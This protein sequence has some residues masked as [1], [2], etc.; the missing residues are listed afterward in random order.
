MIY[1][2]Y[3][4]QLSVLRELGTEFSKKYPALAPMLAGQSADPDVERLIEGTAFLTG[5]IQAKLD[6]DFPELIHSMTSLMFPHYLYPIPSATIIRFSGRKELV[7]EQLIEKGAELLS[8]PVSGIRCIYTTVDNVTVYPLDVRI[9][10][11]SSKVMELEFNFRTGSLKTFDI[12]SLRIYVGG[13]YGEAAN[14][15]FELN[16]KLQAVVISDSRHKIVLRP[17]EAVK[18]LSE[19]FNSIIP[20]NQNMFGAFRKIQEYFQLPES[21]CFF[22][23]T[24]LAKL[25]SEESSFKV[26]FEFTDDRMAEYKAHKN[27]NFELFCVPAVNYFKHEADTINVDY[28]QREY[29]IN[30]YGGHNYYRIY[31]ID[32]VVGFIQGSVSQR[33]YKPFEQFNPS[34]S[35]CPVYSLIRRRSS[36]NRGIDV[37]ITVANTGSPSEFKSETLVISVTCTN[38]VLADRLRLGDINQPT[39]KLPLFIDY[40]NITHPTSSVE[41]PLGENLLWRLLSHIYLNQSSIVSVGALRSLL[42]LYVF[43][44][45]DNKTRAQ[46]NI[47]KVESI[48]DVKEE[49]TSRMI[50]GIYIRGK[51]L[52]IFFNPDGFAS[53]GDMFIFASV[54]QKMAG[55]YT[56][57]NNFTIVHFIDVSTGNEFVCQDLCTG[58]RKIL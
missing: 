24:G 8:I 39:D 5:Q 23:L 34:V 51:L 4:H 26:S 16:S 20:Y 14:F 18:T 25:N 38:G 28:R 21:F 47:H 32:R 53:S 11:D 56:S 10:E 7:D 49:N 48:V 45:T 1:K 31:S 44:D 22:D 50:K 37:Y 9:S 33:E 42:K 13:D 15:I 19:H 29:R 12:N 27:I 30:P 46:I 41:S 6:D 55:A 35:D 54:I 17:S 40:T 58:N 36:L 2:Y 3:Q 52:K 57:I 43:T